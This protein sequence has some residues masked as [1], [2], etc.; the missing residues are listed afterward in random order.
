[1]VARF[2][3][4][5]LAAGV[6]VSLLAG[7]AF[8]PP[9]DSDGGGPPNLPHPTVTHTPDNSPPSAIASVLAQDMRVPWA[10]AFLPDGSALVTERNTR[11]IVKLGPEADADGLKKTPVQTIDQATAAGDGGLLGI[12]V[13]PNYAVDQTVFIYYTTTTDNRIAKLTLGAAPEPIVTGIPM[14]DV[15][16]G[17]RLR[18]GPDGFLYAST[19]DA[20]SPPLAQ[21]PAS[22][23]GK[24]LRMTVDGKPAPGNPFPDSLVYTLGHRDV[25][26]FDWN[27]SGQLMAT[28]MGQTTGDELNPIVAGQNYGW[29]TVDGPARRPPFVDPILQWPTK[30]G[31]CAGAAFA[32]NVLAVSCLQG[33]R[34]W[35]VRLSDTGKVV[36]T[37]AASLVGTFGRLREAVLAPD[38]TIWVTTSNYDGNGSPKPGDDKVLRIV[39]AG[40]G[41]TSI[42]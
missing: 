7:C 19:G 33:Q 31:S 38:G 24:I 13:S 41:G 15:D 9:T 12:A 1:V 34:L 18:F 35:L 14:S 10:I 25:E 36:G 37:P 29:P 23:A 28:D 32:G 16:N 8:G 40:G 2:P 22:L 20:K 42:L 11:Q 17:G 39:V 6:C 26:G 5:A 4:I 27:K 30:D 21:D 3:S